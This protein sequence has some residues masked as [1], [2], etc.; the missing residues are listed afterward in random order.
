MKKIITNLFTGLSFVTTAQ[1]SVYENNNTVRYITTTELNATTPI[2][3]NKIEIGNT[4]GANFTS[5]INKS[6]AAC[7]EVRLK[8][9]THLKAPATSSNELHIDVV[10]DKL[11]IFSH[12]H[13]DL[14]QIHA[15]EK[16]ETSVELPLEIAQKIAAYKQNELDTNGLNPFLEWDVSLKIKY[17]HLSTGYSHFNYG[18]YY[19]DYA[20]NMNGG[21]GNMENWGWNLVPNTEGFRVRYAFPE[22]NGLWKIEYEL[23]VKNELYYSYC[24]F[25]V[26][27]ID[28]NPEDGFVRVADNNRVLQRNNDLFL[29]IGHN[30]KWPDSYQ[31]ANGDWMSCEYSTEPC[32]SAAFYA[33]DQQLQDFANSNIDYFRML[34]SPGSI[35]FEFEKMGNYFNRLNYAKEI[36]K[37]IEFAEDEDMYVDFNMKVHYNLVDGPVYFF[38]AWDGSDYTA[39]GFD[40]AYGLQQYCYIEEL[41]MNSPI[42]FFT[43]TEAKKFYKQK[44][45]YL[46]SRW[47]YSTHIAMFELISEI[48]Q[49]GDV[50]EIDYDFP[51][52]IAPSDTSSWWEYSFPITTS[53]P[54]VS[55]ASN[56]VNTYLWQK[57]MAAYIKHDLQH[58]QHLLTCSYAGGPGEGDSTFSIPELDLLSVN[59][60]SFGNLNNIVSLQNNLKAVHQL[61]NKPIIF[62]ESGPLDELTCSGTYSY[63]QQLWQ[64]AFSGIAGFNYWNADRVAFAT[65]WAEM[66][67]L[68][69]WILDDPLKQS[70]LLGDWKVGHANGTVRGTL[71]SYWRKDFNYIY[72]TATYPS[73]FKRA[74]GALVN[75]TDNYYTNNEADSNWCMA[76]GTQNPWLGV[77]INFDGTLST[78]QRLFVKNDL[79][80]SNDPLYM[81]WGYYEY[82]SDLVWYDLATFD[83]IPGDWT[84]YNSSPLS[85]PTLYVTNEAIATHG[86]RAVVPFEGQFK[87]IS[88]QGIAQNESEAVPL[89][90]AVENNERLEIVEVRKAPIRAEQQPTMYEVYITNVMG[91]KIYEGTIDLNNQNGIFTER[92]PTGILII[93]LIN[94]NNEKHTV[95][96]LNL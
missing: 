38:F 44:L 63:T 96:W 77:R 10:A 84:N 22:L 72:E 51:E 23:F 40:E 54:Y 81:P 57:E 26:T 16:F 2:D 56:R 19:E 87:E 61:Y 70:I 91:Q 45:R 86:N 85:H 89:F 64:L 33:Y 28:K 29:P 74:F 6:I 62:S 47:G 76:W 68:K 32:E 92:F 55:N 42:E 48:N 8:P 18:F 34:L 52:D 73:T 5:N 35:D 83:T 75:L 53:S 49:V 37:I 13:T 71:N 1:V 4:G 93:T 31:K 39:P 30:L 21:N 79:S 67:K 78:N 17:T 36:D 88:E 27:V 58:K 9:N 69:N 7:T 82:I 95:R 94:N 15:L 65:E 80:T 46:L 43:N 12:S 3:D 25:M 90:T 24:P 66:N 14:T 41:N 60:Y 50:V 20:R 59:M 11:E